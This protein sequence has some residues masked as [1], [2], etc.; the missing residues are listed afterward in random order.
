MPFSIININKVGD[1]AE[2]ALS[3]TPISLRLNPE[4]KQNFWPVGDE[5]ALKR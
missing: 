5:M 2:K 4:I 1:N 3:I